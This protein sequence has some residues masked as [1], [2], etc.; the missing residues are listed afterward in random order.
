[1]NIQDTGV[2]G[3]LQWLQRDQPGIYQRIAPQLAQQVPEAFSDYEQSRAMGA[4]MG[5]GD[6][7]GVGFDT[8][9]WMSETNAQAGSP[10]VASAANQGASSSGIVSTIANLVSAA[11][12]IFMAKSQVDTLKQVN[13][14]QLQRAQLGLAPLDMSTYKLGVPQVNVGLSSGAMT[15]GGIAL[16]VVAGLGLMFALSGRRRARA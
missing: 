10:D 8:T 15:G 3:Y 2:R 16:A 1:M 9:G 11:G 12:S 13:N 14:I 7:T 5:L 4:L 6:D